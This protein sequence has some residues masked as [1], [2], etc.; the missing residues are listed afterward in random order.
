MRHS[1]EDYHEFRSGVSQLSKDA[2]G[3]HEAPPS[4]E[5]W[6]LL[7]VYWCGYYFFTL[8]FT[9]TVFSLWFESPLS[10]T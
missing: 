8:N 6:G 2:E 4:T 7:Y 1:V 9:V 5:E 3:E 10:V